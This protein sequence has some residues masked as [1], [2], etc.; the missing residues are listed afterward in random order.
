M[1][2]TD[3]AVED[4]CGVALV[5]VPPATIHDPTC[6]IAYTTPPSRFGV[7]LAGTELTTWFCG[8][9]SCA[10]ACRA[11][12]SPVAVKAAQIY[13]HARGART[14]IRRIRICSPP[15]PPGGPAGSPPRTGST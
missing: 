13:V 5:N 9:D 15:P 10:L 11:T 3:T 14:Q 4:P 2:V 8:T 6:A 1:P 12:A 7:K